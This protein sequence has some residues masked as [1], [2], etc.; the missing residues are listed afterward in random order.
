MST[1]YGEFLRERLLDLIPR[2]EIDHAYVQVQCG[3]KAIYWRQLVDFLSEK[4]PGGSDLDLE[5]AFGGFLVR[6]NGYICG[7]W[8]K[9]DFEK[10]VIHPDI[11]TDAEEFWNALS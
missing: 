11:I 6:Y 5:W 7:Q 3:D 10:V 1:N 9:Y 8:N 2:L 4:Y